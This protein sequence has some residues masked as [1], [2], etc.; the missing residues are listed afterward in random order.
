MSQLGN[1]VPGTSEA[2]S[3]IPQLCKMKPEIVVTNV[4]TQS[5]RCL[6]FLRTKPVF[7]YFVLFIY[8]FI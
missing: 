2:L 3:L 8:L 6:I 7:V 5:R 4:L 1:L